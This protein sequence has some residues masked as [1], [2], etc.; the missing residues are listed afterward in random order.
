MNTHVSRPRMRLSP[1][2]IVPAAL[3]CIG[4]ICLDAGAA[5]PSQTPLTSR[6][7]DSPP[8][9]VMITLDD[10]GSMVSDF[11]PV[12]PVNVQGT[13]VQLDSTKVGDHLG[14]FIGDPR[15]SGLGQLDGYIPALYQRAGFAVDLYQMQ[16]RSPDVNTIW[17]NPEVR[18]RPWLKPQA[19]SDGTGVYMDNATPSA[20]L[21]DPTGTGTFDLTTT[22][23]QANVTWCTAYNTTCTKSKKDFYPGLF[24]RLKSGKSPSSTAN[25]EE[26]NVNDAAHYS[27]SKTAKAAARTDCAAATTCT[28]TEERINFAN[29][30]TYARMRETLAKGALTEALF[31]FQNKLRVGFG[32]INKGSSQVDGINYNVVQLAVRNLDSTQLNTVLTAVQAFKS[33]NSTPLRLA[34]DY[35]GKYFKGRTDANSPWLNTIGD[36]ASGKLSCR[37]SINLLTTDGY[38][39]DTYK[40]AGD[41]TNVDGNVGNMADGTSKGTFDYPYDGATGTVNPGNFSPTH[42]VAQRPYVDGKSAT[43]TANIASDTLTDAA[44]K[45]YI[46]DLDGT[47]V[48]KVTPTDTDIAFW[49]HLTQF[50]IGIGVKGTLD[51]STPTAKA[52]TL[53]ALSD[54]NGTTVWPKN[55]SDIRKIDDMWHAAVNT[56]G[57]FY[58]VKNGAELSSAITNVFSKATGVDSR[59]AGVATVA[60]TLTTTNLKFVPQYKSG[61]WYGDVYAYQ[62]DTSGN[63]VGTKAKW[64]ASTKLPA[65]ASRKLYTW[66]G[67]AGV[68]FK[69]T[70]IPAADLTT[71]GSATLVD[72]IRGDTTNEGNSLTYRPRGGQFLGDFINSPPVYVRDLLDSSYGSLTDTTE[73]GSYASF[74]AAKKARTEGALAVG[75]NAG[76]FHIFR[77]SDGVETFG[78]LPRAG[79]PNLNLIASKTYGTTNN[80]HRFFVDGP[81]AEADAYITTKGSS[82]AAWANMLVG[83]MGAGGKSVFALHVPTSD[84]TTLTANSVQWE[85]NNDADLGFVMN[86]MRTGKIHGAGWYAFIGNGPYST[87]GNAALLIVD[88]Q[89][90]AV[91]KKIVV[92]TSGANGL[93]GVRLLRNSSTMEVYAAYAGDLQGNLW[94]FDFGN[95]DPS[96]W[97]I[98]FVGTPLFKATDAAGKAQPIVAAPAVVPHVSKGYMVTFGTGRLIDASDSAVTDVQTYYGVWDDTAINGSAAAVASPFYAASTSGGTAP[99]RSVL[100]EQTVNSTPVAGTDANAGTSYYTISSN[101]VDWTT[102]KGWFIDLHL[103]PGQRTIYPAQTILNYVYF[104]TIVPAVQAAACEATVGSGYNFVVDGVTGAAITTQVFDTNGDGKVDSS[105]EVVGGYQTLADGVDKLLTNQTG[106]VNEYSTSRCLPDLNSQCPPD[107]CLVVIVNTTN[108]AQQLCVP[109]PHCTWDDPQGDA[110]CLC[111][112]GVTHK[113]SETDT[114]TSVITDRVWRQIMNPPQPAAPSP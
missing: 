22:Q 65:A 81:T 20:A 29:W 35:V 39:N 6:V 109:G 61:A 64:Q 108:Q 37:R 3:L 104:S 86:D 47:V 59:E 21:W 102:K 23:S 18:Y 96:S 15:K 25:F 114:C 2:A 83:S 36:T 99:Y 24:Y 91:V 76:V 60:S 106:L 19:L 8:P 30:F 55:D 67:T 11:M 4:S 68:E 75:G 38:Y 111:P 101:P 73:A 110:R 56:G 85:L 90:G 93:G 57:D 84:P 79:F 80:F 92:P 50:M 53:A 58:S 31:G 5:E 42:Y 32:R 9:N 40:A 54:P 71:I 88:L 100:I 12:G 63:V 78:Y 7:G 14:A 70:T 27:P 94:R 66:S 33:G 28:Q 46:Q 43:D 113:K 82:G 62:L 49:Q 1:W 41:L 69:S 95:S 74:L 105:D 44:M 87:N 89:T 48:N 45:W 13:T 107:S 51:S 10:S 72:Y 26:Y 112:D 103:Q 52:A 98:S 17:Y 77:G 16:F 34:V 97:V